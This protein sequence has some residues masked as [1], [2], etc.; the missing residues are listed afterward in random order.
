MKIYV[1]IYYKF[2]KNDKRKVYISR[3]NYL[4]NSKVALVSLNMD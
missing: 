4:K 2:I 1:N 3:L